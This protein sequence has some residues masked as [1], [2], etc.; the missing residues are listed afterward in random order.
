[1]VSNNRFYSV[2]AGLSFLTSIKGISFLKGRNIGMI[3]A[4]YRTE[5]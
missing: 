4:I 2:F 5:K 3:L 1:M